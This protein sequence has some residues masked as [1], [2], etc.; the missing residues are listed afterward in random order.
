MSWYNG[1]NKQTRSLF[2]SAGHSDTDPGARGN[3]TTEAEV[4][5]KLRDLLCEELDQRGMVLTRDGEEGE[6][7]PLHD[8]W[9]MASEHDVA[10]EFHLNAATPAATG[11]ETLSHSEHKPLGELL[12][13]AVHDTL[14]IANRGAKGEGSGQHSRLAFVSDG[15]G[16]ILEMF[17]VTNARDVQA[18][19]SNQRA[20]VQALAAVLVEEVT[21]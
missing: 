11:V 21:A 6:N 7:L 8:A 15:G 3:G 4:V 17:F 1:A 5:T 13:S 14:D 19:Y 16:I 12:C 2:I 18:Y 10:V 20:V 9:R